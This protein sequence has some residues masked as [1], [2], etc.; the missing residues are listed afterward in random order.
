MKKVYFQNWQDITYCKTP[1]GNFK[2]WSNIVFGKGD[3]N[4]KPSKSSMLGFLNWLRKNREWKKF[5]I[6][7][8]EGDSNTIFRMG[9]YSEQFR[10]CK[11]SSATRKISDGPFA[12]RMGPEDCYFF[13][14]G[15]GEVKVKIPGYIRNDLRLY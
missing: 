6:L 2:Y 10:I 5:I 7:L 13:I 15:T 8:P 14:V 12:M 11:I 9:F 4:L 3:E 1:L